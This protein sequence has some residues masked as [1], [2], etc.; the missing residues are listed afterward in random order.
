MADLNALDTSCDMSAAPVD[1][2]LETVA[3]S[4]LAQK[5]L[6]VAGATGEALATTAGVLT[7]QLGPA[8]RG[9]DMLLDRIDHLEA[10][11]APQPKKG[12]AP[13]ERRPGRW[14]RRYRNNVK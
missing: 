2:D 11:C 12:P 4:G 14:K 10:V 3:G 9:C 13:S 7:R 6:G 5:A 8:G 1:A